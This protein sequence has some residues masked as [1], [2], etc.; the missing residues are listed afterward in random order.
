M[1]RLNL[2]DNN[3][4]ALIISSPGIIAAVVSLLNYIQ[5]MFN[6]KQNTAGIAKNAKKLDQVEDIVNGR[7]SELIDFTKSSS[8]AEGIKFEK[9][10]NGDCK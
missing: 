2:S 1:L 3:I 7:M 5:N 4:T 10:K 9:D 6:H 8:F